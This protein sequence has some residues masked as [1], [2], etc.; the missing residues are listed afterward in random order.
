MPCVAERRKSAFRKRHILGSV[1]PRACTK[2]HLSPAA[3]RFGQTSSSTDRVGFIQNHKR[4]ARQYTTVATGGRAIWVENTLSTQEHETPI[5]RS[6]GILGRRIREKRADA[7]RVRL[8]LMAYRPRKSRCRPT[9]SPRGSSPPRPRSRAACRLQTAARTHPKRRIAGPR[10]IAKVRAQHSGC[11]CWLAIR[12]AP[13]ET[14]C[15]L[16]AKGVVVRVVVAIHLLDSPVGRPRRALR[17]SPGVGRPALD[18]RL[19]V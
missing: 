12:E 8:T 4:P 7:G 14:L 18:D 19:V 17:D 16:C 3:N 10:R 6:P 11:S 13:M 9:A 5:C 1:V 2:I 15:K